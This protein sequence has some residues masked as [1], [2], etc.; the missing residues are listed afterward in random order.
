MTPNPP[1]SEPT[2]NDVIPM[3]GRTTPTWE[4]ELLVS[5]ATVFG[6]LQ[7]PSLTDRVLFGLYNG[8]GLE[9]ASMI[10]PLWVYVKF[11][12]LTLIFTFIAHLCLRGYWV[13]LVGLHSVYPLGIQWGNLDKK[14]GPNYVAASRET[15]GTM[16][17]IIERADNRA[18]RVFGVGFGMATTMLMP[19]VLVSLLL[20]GIRIYLALGGPGG[21]TMVWV[22]MGA[23]MLLFLPFGLLVLWD[24]QRGAAMAPESFQSRC[25]RAAFRFY[26][27]LGM[28]RASNPLITLFASNEGG[29][30]SSIVLGTMMGV[31]MLVVL[32][33]GVGPRLGWDT[34]SF[35][36]LPKDR[37]MSPDTVLPVHYA[38]Q[39]GS[40]VMLV[41]PPH[42]PDPVVRGSYL[43]LF[44]PYLPMR[45][46]PAMQRLCPEALA[47]TD[48]GASRAR[49]DCLASIHALA[50]D[51]QA[52]QVPFD[53]GED[54]ATGQRGMVAMIPVAALS[55]GRHEL[56]VMPVRADAP[57]EGEA[58]LRP[59]R[60]LF[61]R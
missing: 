12:V 31:V 13:A 44:V 8:S 52:L 50:V 29:R 55:P 7:L 3:P 56:T 38:S 20:V 48:D 23:V 14:M 61:W 1:D 16:A 36:G 46:T 60:I 11:T 5:G 54:P 10:T 51:G 17:Q 4:M 59:Y 33:E 27:K 28:S 53:A 41:P 32:A 15:V 9:M 42:I 25:L 24:R 18:S 43:K 6:L 57:E 35:D 26:G 34:G 30:S 19:I 21:D 2:A 22:V 49:L 58:P 47:A 45:H 37:V 39:R 40:G